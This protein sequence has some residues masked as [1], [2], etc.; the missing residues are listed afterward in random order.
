MRKL[1]GITLFRMG[2]FW[3]GLRY[4]NPELHGMELRNFLRDVSQ[5][6]RVIVITNQRNF[7]NNLTK[8]GGSTS[9]ITKLAR[10]IMM[11]SEH[12]RSKVWE[13][14]ILQQ[15]LRCKESEL[16]RA[17]EDW[18]RISKENESLIPKQLVP[19]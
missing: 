10:D 8:I 4:S 6:V 14:R 11:L 2:Q 19:E 9:E 12:Q 7:L 3:D 1:T 15:R 18:T 17:R 13:R 5:G 16:W